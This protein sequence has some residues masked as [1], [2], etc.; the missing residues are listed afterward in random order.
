M[1]VHE[2]ICLFSVDQTSHCN[3]DVLMHHLSLDHVSLD[4]FLGGHMYSVKTLRLLETI[5][6][7]SLKMEYWEKSTVVSQVG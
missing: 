2:N 4:R 3:G 5:N 7:D 6:N 1:N